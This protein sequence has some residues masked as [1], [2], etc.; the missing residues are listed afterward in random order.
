MTTHH[1]TALLIPSWGHVVSYISVAIQMLQKDPTLV[2]TLVQH[3]IDVAKMEVELQTWA[4]DTSRLRIIAVG[5][6]DLNLMGPEGMKAAFG[7]LIKGWLQNA[8]QLAQGSEGWPKPHSIHIDHF[9]GGMVIEPTRTI[10]GSDCKILLWFSAG[11]A[12]L[13][14]VLHDHDFL[15]IAQEIYADE[16]R[17]EGRSLEDILDQVAGVSNG[18]DKLS[19]IVMKCP[20]VPDLYDY[21]RKAHGAS[22]GVPKGIAT[23]LVAAQ[24]FAKLTDGFIVPSTTCF[25]PVALPYYREFYQKRGQ[26]FFTVG[27]QA[28][29]L[30]WTD[31]APVPPTNELVRSFLDKA[32]SQHGPNSVLYIS[33]G[34]FFFPVATPKL[35][36]LLVTTLLDLETPF[37]F[38]FSLGGKMASL[39]KELIE[40]ANS[41]GKALICDFWVEQRAI[42][43]HG[44]VGWFLTHG[45]YNSVCESLSTG[46]PLI[47]WPVTAEQPVNA[48][49]L[50]SG[51]NP[52]AIELVQ[53]RA[54]PSIAPS[55]RGG[56]KIT[57]TVEDVSAEFKAAFEAARGAKGAALKANTV[58]MAKALRE[59]RAGEASD[60]LIRLA[61][62]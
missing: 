14:G 20:G 52:V 12:S 23:I 10:M 7:Q 61:K 15:A 3:H 55:L 29:E 24:K 39:P 1:I 33:F 36:E 40:R 2:I 19:G 56:P 51:P 54:G 21:E 30:C 44:A 46:T 6:T 42:L 32:V 27:L 38:I 50:S 31:A 13:K 45:G 34:S 37:P 60:E 35:I 53:I 9:A 41:S 43:H 26:E 58:N 57:G 18:T 11:L 25:E 28:H 62:F 49:L 4:Y 17:R 48:A 8:A 5:E 22:H 47:V 16:A 59:A